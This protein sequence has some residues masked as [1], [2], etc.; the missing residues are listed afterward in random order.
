M[1][2]FA[3]MPVLT[4]PLV[5][6]SPLNFLYI[7]F[8]D[9]ITAGWQAKLF[10]RGSIKRLISVKERAVPVIH[11]LMK[12]YAG[13]PFFEHTFAFHEKTV[14]SNFPTGTKKVQDPAE[15]HTLPGRHLVRRRSF[16]LSILDSSLIFEV[17]NNAARRAHSETR[18]GQ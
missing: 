16:R 14:L 15:A 1:I 2:Q 7:I 12:S 13:H 3:F 8:A 4:A 9:L 11:R 10:F 5:S 17:V 18:S 6:F